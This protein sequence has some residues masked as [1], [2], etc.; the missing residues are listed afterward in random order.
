M[1]FTNDRVVI[2]DAFASA[3]RYRDGGVGSPLIFLHAYLGRSDHGRFKAP[4]HFVLMEPR[5]GFARHLRAEVDALDLRGAT[6]DVIH[7]SYEDEF[8]RIVRYLA[9]TY[10]PPLPTFLFVDRA[11]VT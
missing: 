9:A 3:G 2:I 4:P 10:R 6:V 11:A 8:P 5:L 1:G 7:G